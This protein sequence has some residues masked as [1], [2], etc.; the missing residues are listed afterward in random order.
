MSSEVRARVAGVAPGSGWLG[1]AVAVGLVLLLGWRVVDAQLSGHAWISS[2]PMLVAPLCAAGFVHAALRPS[3]PRSVLPL[4]T[5]AVLAAAGWW[6]GVVLLAVA[7]VL[8]IASWVGTGAS[9]VEAD[10]SAAT[11]AG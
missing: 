1:A 8:L 5:A 10:E 3:L 11:P 9:D 4:L 2:V 6:Q 7:L